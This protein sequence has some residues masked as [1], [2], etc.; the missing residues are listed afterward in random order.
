MFA[1]IKNILNYAFDYFTGAKSVSIVSSL[2]A[3]K[4]TSNASPMLGTAKENQYILTFPYT[5][6]YRL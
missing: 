6:Y 4:T 2:G 5:M 1:K 3:L